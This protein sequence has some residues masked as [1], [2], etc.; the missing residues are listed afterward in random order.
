[1]FF[2]VYRLPSQS[3]QFGSINDWNK[4]PYK[5][6]N[7]DNGN[8][9]LIWSIQGDTIYMGISA[10]TKGWVAIGM[11]PEQAM[12]KADILS[13][14]GVEKRGI[15]TVVF[16]RKLVTGDKYDKKIPKNGKINITWATVLLTV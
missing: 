16:T 13:Q 7:F 9:R 1:M 15:T 3:I 14:K 10:G 6:A 5:K 12:D 2:S 4:F 11:E 8:Y